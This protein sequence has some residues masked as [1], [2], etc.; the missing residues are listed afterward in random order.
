VPR[1]AFFLHDPLDIDGS[2]FTIVKRK[3]EERYGETGL[4]G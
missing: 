2:A 3:D 4:S 1:F